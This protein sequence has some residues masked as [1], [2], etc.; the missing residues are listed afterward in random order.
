MVHFPAVRQRKSLS[1]GIA[2][3]RGGTDRG[4]GTGTRGGQQLALSQQARSL[5]KGSL[6]PNQMEKSK[7]PHHSCLLCRHGMDRN[8]SFVMSLLAH[9]GENRQ[10]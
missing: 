2:L 4:L 6:K 7:M 10:N 1:V 8:S 9:N 3:E 5:G